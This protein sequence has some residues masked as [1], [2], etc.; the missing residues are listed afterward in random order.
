MIDITI[1]NFGEL[2]PELQYQILELRQDVFII[3]QNC[4]YNDIDG[5]DPYCDHL[6]LTE[7]EQLI[8]YARLVPAGKLF[9]D[10]SI[11]RIVVSKSNRNNGYGRLIIRKALNILE[12]RGAKKVV[13][14]AQN[15]LRDYYESEGF[16]AEGSVYVL[17]GIPHVKMWQNFS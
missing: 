12:L 11:G 1:K 16:V 4:I 5:V 9:D 10:P 14:E 17:D 6:C 13:I 8:C 3:E 2:S 7:D 15:H